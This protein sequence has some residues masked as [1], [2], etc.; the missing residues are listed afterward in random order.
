[1][2]ATSPPN[3]GTTT[4]YRVKTSDRAVDGF[5]PGDELLKVEGLTMH[6]PITSGAFFR[7][8][9]GAVRA[10]DGLDFTIKKGETLGLVGESGLRQE[11]GRPRNPP[12]I[13]TDRR[14][15]DLQRPRHRPGV[16]E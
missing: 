13:Q 1:M 6:F 7:R 11:H 2:A 4:D 14:Q 10:V 5:V 12:V 3:T 16:P 8:Q 15:G 9:V